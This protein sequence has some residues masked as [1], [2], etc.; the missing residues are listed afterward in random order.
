MKLDIVLH[1]TKKSIGLFCASDF[2]NEPLFVFFNYNKID[3]SVISHYK[4]I[5]HEVIEASDLTDYLWNKY[6]DPKYKNPF[7]DKEDL[8][9]ISQLYAR[10]KNIDILKQFKE[11]TAIDY[12]EIPEEVDDFFLLLLV[13][14]LQERFKQIPELRTQYETEYFQ[15]YTELAKRKHPEGTHNLASCYSLGIGTE[16]SEEKT[17]ALIKEA[18][19]LGCK[20]SI[21]LLEKWEKE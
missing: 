5:S 2:L 1:N 18:A 7:I 21:A 20:E 16:I 8:F 9:H 11:K 15:I 10:V 17:K 14:I 13:E 4:E 3:D 12:S 19:K 6:Y